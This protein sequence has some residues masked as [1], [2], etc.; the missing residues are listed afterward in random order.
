M[1]DAVR[2]LELL[3]YREYSTAQAALVGGLFGSLALVG[4]AAESAVKRALKKPP[5]TP[6][7][8][9]RV[10]WIVPLAPAL[11]LMVGVQAFVYVGCMAFFALFAHRAFCIVFHSVGLKEVPH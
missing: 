11:Y 5:G 6:W 3:P 7:W 9:D 1:K 4:D 8:P 2:G 10:D